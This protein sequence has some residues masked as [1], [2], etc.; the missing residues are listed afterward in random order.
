VVPSSPYRLVRL[1]KPVPT[2][3]PVAG[4]SLGGSIR[5]YRGRQRQ[6]HTGAPWAQEDLAVA[7]GS[8][9]SHVNRIER[10]RCI[11]TRATLERIANALCL[12]WFERVELLILANYV[13]EPPEPTD[14]EVERVRASVAPLL[15]DS[16]YGVSLK[17]R[18]MRTWDMNDIAAF[19]SFGFPNRESGLTRMLGMSTFEE[20]LDDSIRGWQQR[21]ILDYPAYVTRQLTRCQGLFRYHR[22]DPHLIEYARRVEEDALLGPIWR[23]LASDPAAGPVFL[24]H[25]VV[26]LN[27]PELGQISELVWHSSLA[28]DERFLI[29][30][31][32]PAEPSSQRVLEHLWRRF[33]TAR[34]GRGPSSISLGRP[35]LAARVSQLAAH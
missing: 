17:D 21:V 3:T 28:L 16:P 9:K 22:F 6:T 32:V 1:V 35:A 30:H 20:M 10:D 8:D 29:S 7:I 4:E 13:V 12:T 5:M 15:A 31:H 33:K 25:Q 14:S 19:V 26:A 11:P 2:Q 34:T 27:H 24:D 23:S 18:Q